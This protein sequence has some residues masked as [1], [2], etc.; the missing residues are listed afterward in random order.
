MRTICKYIGSIVLALWLLGVLNI[1]D[2]RLCI[3]PVGSCGA[4]RAAGMVA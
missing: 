3:G 4:P 1:I 2:F